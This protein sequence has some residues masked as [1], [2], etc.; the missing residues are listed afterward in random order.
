MSNLVEQYGMNWFLS[1][2]SGS[3][4]MHEDKPHVVRS[5]VDSFRYTVNVPC[6]SLEQTG[7]STI[8][9]NDVSIPA[10]E[11]NDISK[12]SVGGL[13]W[14]SSDKGRYLAYFKRNNRSYHR[15][16]SLRN[17]VIEVSH[18]TKWL[19][20][21][22]NYNI[23]RDEAALAW[24]SLRPTFHSLHEGLEMVRNKEIVSFAISPTIAIMPD[25]DDKMAILFKTLKAGTVDLDGNMQLS[26]PKIGSLLEN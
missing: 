22:T 4:F 24:L 9:R 15:G 5:D 10:T 12:F 20:T 6:Y 25:K 7:E 8:S 2:F 19:S 13:G 17:L 11:F 23:R 18:M 3:F 16:L 21:Y 26:I 1:K 14:R